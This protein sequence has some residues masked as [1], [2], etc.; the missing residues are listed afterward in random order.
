MRMTLNRV[1]LRPWCVCLCA[2]QQV[3]GTDGGSGPAVFMQELANPAKGLRLWGEKCLCWL[4]PRLQ[5]WCNGTGRF[6]SVT[7]SSI[8]SLRLPICRSDY[9]PTW[10]SVACL[11]FPLVPLTIIILP[12]SSSGPHSGL[13]MQSFFFLELL[14]LYLTLQWVCFLY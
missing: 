5:D 7:L 9:W 10:I 6:L 14:V 8:L 13:I 2:G 4:G 11:S 1:C 3:W 12:G